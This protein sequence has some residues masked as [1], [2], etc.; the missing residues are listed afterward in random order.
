VPRL[1]EQVGLVGQFDQAAEVHH[2]DLVGHV[3]HHR[4]VVR[5]EQ[6]GQPALALQVLHDVEHLRLHRH[7]ERRGRLVADQELGLGGQRA[8]DRDALALAA[9]ELVRELVASA[10]A[11]P[12][13]A[14]ARRPLAQAARRR[15]SRGHARACGSATMSSTF[16]RGFRLA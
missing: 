8:R 15:R 4:Q 11:R 5:D 6:I 12:T 7:V 13:D 10:A 1:R 3:P 16:Q 14:A 9:G 2:A